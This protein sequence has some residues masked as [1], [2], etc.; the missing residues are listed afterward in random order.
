M[1]LSKKLKYKTNL[2]LMSYAYILKHTLSHTH[3]ESVNCLEFSSSGEFLAS[4]SDDHS[5]IIWNVS[6]GQDLYHIL[7]DSPV[8][9]L[10]WHPSREQT[11]ICGCEDGTIVQM[12]R[13][14]LVRT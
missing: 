10:L 4:G 7:F 14:T 9:A 13:F 2:F 6:T 1:H 5:L 8:T 3:S 11:I 12:S